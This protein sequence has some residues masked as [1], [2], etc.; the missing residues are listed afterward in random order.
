MRTSRVEKMIKV[1]IYAVLRGHIKMVSGKRSYMNLS[2]L[3]P[4]SLNLE[5]T[6]PDHCFIHA[7]VNFSLVRFISRSDSIKRLAAS[8]TTLVGRTQALMFWRRWEGLSF[9]FRF[10]ILIYSTYL[11]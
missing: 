2:G 9:P 6:F 3:F 1:G 4:A 8:T 11:V 10:R 5:Q 7:S